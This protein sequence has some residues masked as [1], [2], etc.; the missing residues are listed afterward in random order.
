MS[1]TKRGLKYHYRFNCQKKIYSGVCK[2]CTTEAAAK[3]YEKIQRDTTV[4]A[5]NS[6]NEIEKENIEKIYR[7]QTGIV[8]KKIPLA[9]GFKKFIEIGRSNTF[10]DKAKSQKESYWRDFTTYMQSEH[11]EVKNIDDVKKEHAKIYIGY[12]QNHGRFD[13]TVNLPGKESYDQ[14]GKIG[15]RTIN[16]FRGTL[17]QIFNAIAEKNPFA[18]VEKLKEKDR[19]YREIFSE[20][21]IKKIIDNRDTDI[22]CF[23]II[24]IGIYTGLRRGDICTLKWN[25]VDLKAGYIHRRMLKTG[26]MVDIPIVPPLHKYLALLKQQAGDG[27]YV[28]PE[29]ADRYQRNPDGISVRFKAYLKKLKIKSREEVPERCRKRSIKDIHSFRHNYCYYAGM[30]NVPFPVVQSIVGHLDKQMTELYQ[31][32]TSRKDKT[33]RME[34]S[35]LYI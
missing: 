6:S 19:G 7:K 13:K 27:E 34:L 2:E 31:R 32:H 1:V 25:E 5:A 22:F 12:L 21:D 14:E 29:H 26:E 10:G 3:A 17:K 9:E 33:Q 16:V 18:E 35:E 28:L 4:T 24:A 15:S 23:Q 20:D 8:T 11:P 30:Y